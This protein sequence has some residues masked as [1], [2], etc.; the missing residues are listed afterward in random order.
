[1]TG[2]ASYGQLQYRDVNGSWMAYLDQGE[3]DAIVF[4]HGASDKLIKSG[5]DRYNYAEQRDYLF[6]LW[7]ALDLAGNVTLCYTTGGRRSA[8]TGLACTATAYGES[9][10]WKQSSLR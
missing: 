8:S 9:R 3:G 1:M 2:A 7:D 4:G 5:P 6:A 10:S